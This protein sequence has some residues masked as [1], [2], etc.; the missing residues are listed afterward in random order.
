MNKMIK[1]EFLKGKR[2]VGNIKLKVTE[3]NMI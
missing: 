2:N 1:Y 3:D